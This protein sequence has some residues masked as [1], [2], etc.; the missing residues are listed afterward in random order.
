MVVHCG[1]SLDSGHYYCFQQV[2]T[3]WYL[4][5]DAHVTLVHWEDVANI[6]AGRNK[7]HCP[8]LLLYARW[9]YFMQQS[10]PPQA[11]ENPGRGEDALL[12]P[13][14]RRRV[15]FSPVPAYDVVARYWLHSAGD[16]T[17]A[18]SSVSDDASSTGSPAAS[19]SA[20]CVGI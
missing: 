12:Q 11:E 15:H 18:G 5:N 20:I 1:R 2:R 14:K 8:T 6:A 10:L 13:D 4:F 19:K 9:D 16:T 7:S 3:R 17:D